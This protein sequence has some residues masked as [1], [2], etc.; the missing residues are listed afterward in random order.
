ML[1][2]KLNRDG[3]VGRFESFASLHPQK[4]LWH[5]SRLSNWVG[6]VSTTEKSITLR[7]LITL[8]SK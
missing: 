6:I 1:T 2:F 3:E 4:L 7:K 5:G 8:L